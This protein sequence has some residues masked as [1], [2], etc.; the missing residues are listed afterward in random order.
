VRCCGYEEFFDE[1]LA[2]KDAERYRTKGL[3]ASGRRTVELLRGRGIEGAEVLE[4]GGGVGA[5][6][7]ELVRSGAARATVVELSASYDT[8]SAGLVRE[9]G[10]E[11]RVERLHGDVVEDGFVSD[12]DLVVMERVVCCYPDAPALVGA[13]ARRARRSLVLTYPRYGLLTRAAVRAANLLLRLRGGSFRVYAHAPGAIRVAAAA[14]G[15]QPL[16]PE[17]GVVW[18]TAAFERPALYPSGQ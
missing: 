17:S 9:Y 3:R 16:G 13:A 18:R 5:I 1:K 12:A 8:A 6:G 15:L 11:G 14:H 2:R 4:I 7:I 10:L